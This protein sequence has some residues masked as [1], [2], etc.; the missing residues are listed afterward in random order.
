MRLTAALFMSAL[1]APAMALDNTVPDNGNGT[2]DLPP[3]GLQYVIASGAPPMVIENGFPAGTTIEIDAILEQFVGASE[4]PGGN[5]GGMIQTYSADFV[6]PMTGTGVL[7]G[8]NRQIT[9]PVAVETHSAPRTPFDAVQSFAREFVSMEVEIFGDPDFDLLR[10]RIGTDFGLPAPGHT[11]L[12]DLGTEFQ[13]DS[14]FDVVYEIEF[15]GAPGSVLEGFSGVTE[16]QTRI[17]IPSPAS[18]AALLGMMGL[19]GLKRRR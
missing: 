3:V 10:I 14:F 6:M 9:R 12:T 1:A 4:N 18:G 8:F 13:V 5:L 16:G 2:A 11:T 15:V 7:A 17:A 19:I